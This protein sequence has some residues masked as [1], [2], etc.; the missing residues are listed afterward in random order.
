M[1]GKALLFALLPL[2][3]MGCWD[4]EDLND[5]LLVL[6]AG[7]DQVEGGRL[8]L[9]LQVP[10]VEELLPSFGSPQ[11]S[12]EPFAVLTGEGESVFAAVPTLQSKVQWTLFFGQLKAVLIA[13]ELAA[14][15]LKS[16]IDSFWRHP[17]VPPQAHVFLVKGEAVTMLKHVLWH[18]GVPASS[19]V[20]FFHVK[21]KRDQSF[22]QHLWRL[23]RN[24]YL[25][26]QD[27]FLPIL[28]NGILLSFDLRSLFCNL[29]YCCYSL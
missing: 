4:I 10:I 24:L 16:S 20:T 2:L 23:V 12:E 29:I 19:L 11:V 1:K 28:A 3:L 26:T 14:A 5:R 18:K 21:G 22:E 9:S 8:R 7:V 25:S 27:A 13:E 17:G 6:A 15:G